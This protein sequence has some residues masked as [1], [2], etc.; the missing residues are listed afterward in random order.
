M[1]RGGRISFS[2]PAS[3]T[4]KHHHPRVAIFTGIMATL[5]WNRWQHSSG[6]GGNVE[7]EYAGSTENTYQIL[8][9][10]MQ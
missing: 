8:K 6:I 2:Y 7:P 5:K 10:W 9:P 1:K 3:K 4:L